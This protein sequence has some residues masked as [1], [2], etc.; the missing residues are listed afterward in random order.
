MTVRDWLSASKGNEGLK[1]VKY[2][3]ETYV[4]IH[5]LLLGDSEDETA[6]DLLDA[7]IS[8]LYKFSTSSSPP[9]EL[10]CFNFIPAFIFQIITTTDLPSNYEALILAI[11]NIKRPQPDD[12]VFP[13]LKEDVSSIYHTAENNLIPKRTFKLTYPTLEFKHKILPK[14]KDSITASLVDLLRLYLPQLETMARVNF[15]Q[16]ISQLLRDH[17]PILQ[18]YEHFLCSALQVLFQLNGSKT[19]PVSSSGLVIKNIKEIKKQFSRKMCFIEKRAQMYPPNVKTVGKLQKKTFAEEELLSE[20]MLVSNAMV[21]Y[22][23]LTDSCT[24]TRGTS[25]LQTPD[26]RKVRGLKSGN[27]VKAYFDEE[28][29]V[30]FSLVLQESFLRKPDLK[31]RK[32]NLF[33]SI[34]HVTYANL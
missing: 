21:N 29:Q 31:I 5:N 23:S 20:L 30:W 27:L 16:L 25:F 24:P 9:L 26:L 6:S 17:E 8:Q 34:T 32:I 1:G 13:S 12:V 7:V 11:V 3:E 14:E 33:T 10:F 18:K 19:I 2:S 4:Q 15:I 22:F 28:C